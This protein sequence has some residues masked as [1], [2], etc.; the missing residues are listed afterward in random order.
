MAM[1]LR[2]A[3]ERIDHALDRL[4][5]EPN[6]WIATA[7]ADAVPHLVPLSLAWFQDRVVVATGTSTPTVR[8]L[9]ASS[10]A[11]L[12]LDSADDV[13]IIEATATV[14]DLA[15]AD[16]AVMDAYVERVGWNPANESGEWSLIELTPRRVQAWIGPGEIT[17]RTIMRDGVWLR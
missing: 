14:V 5:R 1:A 11:R 10:N 16:P 7:S 2:T 17:G 4:G 8:N 6:V 15:T 3:T 9:I 13:V 12:T